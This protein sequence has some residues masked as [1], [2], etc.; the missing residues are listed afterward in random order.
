MG[1]Y[2][3]MEASLSWFLSNLDPH[4]I[5]GAVLSSTDRITALPW[6]L[7]AGIGVG[8]GHIHHFSSRGK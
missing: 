7:P 5:P 3:A 6:L 2:N 4:G 8:L 1:K